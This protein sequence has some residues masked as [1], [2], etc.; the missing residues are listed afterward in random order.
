MRYPELRWGT[1]M[2]VAITIIIAD[3]FWLGYIAKPMYDHLR[4]VLNPGISKSKLPYRIIPAIL[5]YIAMVISL[6]TL[7]VPNVTTNKGTMERIKSAL[8]W[9]GMWGLAVYGTYD[10][11]NLAVIQSFPTSTALIDALW[12]LI[13]GSLGAFTG[14]Y[15]Q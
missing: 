11:T 14:S 10:M 4:M 5:A 2:V 9:G 3:Y 6:S 8:M 1:I 12:G 13:L 15:A 7:S